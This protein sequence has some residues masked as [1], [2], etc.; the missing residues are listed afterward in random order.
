[1]GDG[2]EEGPIVAVICGNLNP[3]NRMTRASQANTALGR[4]PGLPGAIFG[5]RPCAV[6]GQGN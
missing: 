2:C 4:V 6:F 1:M 5:A 3:P